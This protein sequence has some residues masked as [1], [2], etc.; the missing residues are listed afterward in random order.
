MSPLD[1]GL[2]FMTLA[3][4]YLVTSS[5][6]PALTVHHGRRLVLAGA[7][8]LASGHITLLVAVHEIGS[9]GSI[10]ALAPGLLLIGAGMGLCITPLTTTVLA[11]ADP[12][13]AGAVSGTLATMQQL[14]NAL[15]VAVTGLIFFDSLDRGIPHA[16]EL[17]LAE[18]AVL[19]LL[20]GAL[21]RLLPAIPA[22]SPE[23]V[24]QAR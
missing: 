13:R 15:G 8:T 21:S 22:T 6:A 20:V 5:R 16:F 9:D 17:S 14:G 19:L 18:L 12:Q 23:P 1:S 4:A 24:E 7:L 2:V 3:A 11:S 10:A